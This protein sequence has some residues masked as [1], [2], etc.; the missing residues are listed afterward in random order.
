MSKNRTKFPVYILATIAFLLSGMPK[1]R[2]VIG[3]PIYFVDVLILCLIVITSSRKNRRFVGQSKRLINLVGLYMFFAV[4][5]EIHGVMVYGHY[6]DASYL[7]LRYALAFALPFVMPKVIRSARDLV[8]VLKGLCAGLFVS[9]L[10]AIFYSLPFM[11]GIARAVFSIK[12]ICPVRESELAQTADALRGQTLIGTSTFSS[13]VMATL[14]PL[15]YMGS[16]LCRR[17]TGWRYWFVVALLLLPVG[18]IAT[19]G[20]S[21]WLSVVLVFGSMMLWGGGKGRMKVIFMVVAFGLIL[22]QIGINSKMLRVDIVVNKTERT[23]NTP[24]KDENER[25]R[26]MAYVDPFRHVMKYPVFFLAGSGAARRKAGGSAYEENKYASHTVPAMA[27]YTCGVGGAIC[28]IM[29]LITVFSLCYSRL[30]HAGRNLPSLVWMWRALLA[31][32]FGMLPWWLFGHGIVSQPRG[33]MVY[34]FFIGMVLAC[35]QLYVAEVRK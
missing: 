2:V 21:A 23:V 34:Y 4:L 19:Y 16:S 11:R 7:M 24:L 26:F 27:Y 1:V 20:R 5:S 31:A 17:I 18:I 3:A 15:L 28:H 13:G 8:V 12:T 9:A 33:A 35:D 14:W 25:D 32:C 29:M 22:S 10:L 30:R 6:F